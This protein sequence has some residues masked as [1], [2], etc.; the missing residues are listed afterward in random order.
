MKPP[1]T[2]HRKRKERGVNEDG[3]WVDLQLPLYRRLLPGIVDERGRSIVDAKAVE[4]GDIRFGYVSLPKTAGES[5][6][7]LAD[8]TEEDLASA[9]RT[10]RNVVR[11][12]REGRIVFDPTVTKVK[13]MGRDGLEPLRTE[14]WR[15]VGTD[16]G[17]L[18]GNEEEGEE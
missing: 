9:E 14:G 8:W 18:R 12:L 11:D 3:R 4:Q 16:E 1:E 2:T 7:M 15:A 10:A 6:F 17:G 5:E 13:R